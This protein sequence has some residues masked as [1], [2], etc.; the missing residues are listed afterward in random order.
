MSRQANEISIELV[1]VGQPAASAVA[2]STPSATMDPEAAKPSSSILSMA[3]LPIPDMPYGA[4]CNFV[5]SIIGAG[6][7]GLPFA[8]RE[9]GLLAG[10]L[11]LLAT[12]VASNYSSTLIVKLGVKQ[13][14]PDYES[15][16][17]HVFGQT[18]T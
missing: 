17:K 14:Q 12:A 2:P 7:I 1:D 9:A 15:L 16:A 13:K 8:L 6:I 3:S 10:I 11:L 5:N 4:I 18:G